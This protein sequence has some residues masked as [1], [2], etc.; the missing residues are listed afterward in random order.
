MK[1]RPLALALMASLLAACSADLTLPSEIVGPHTYGSRIAVV[2]DPTRA[3]PAFGESFVLHEYV[4]GAEELTLPLSERF[5]MKLAVCVG[6][7]APNGSLICAGGLDLDTAVDVVS[8][9]E[10]VSQ[11]IALPPL[12]FL[13]ADVPP[14]F[15]EF[16]SKVNQVAILG[17]VCVQGTVERV[18]GKSPDRDPPSELFRCNSRPDSIYTAPLAF[19]TTVSLDVGTSTPNHNPLFA[20]DPAA[21]SSACNLGVP[22]PLEEPMVPGPIVLVGPEDPKRPNKVPRQASAWNA[23]PTPDTL[24]WTDCANDPALPKIHAGSGEHLIR[25]RFDPSD[26]EQYEYTAEE[27]GK[28]V[29]KETRELVQVSHSV[30][31]FGGELGRYT[32]VVAGEDEDATAEINVKYTPPKK[33]PTDEATIPE[34][35]RLVRIFFALRDFRGGFDFTTRELCLLPAAK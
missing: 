14:E 7:Q 25:V 21:A 31:E 24:P 4:V 3:T 13:T 15:Q 6:F 8:G 27:Y 19:L 5:D 9:T 10:I 20:C 34:G 11:P 22:V 32:S 2:G 33:N 28:L 26:R 35:G 12:E 1:M 16:V 29:T 17:A 18:E 30:T 23:Y